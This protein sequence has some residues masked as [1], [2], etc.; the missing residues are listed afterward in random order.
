VTHFTDQHEPRRGARTVDD[1]Q[2]PG[3]PRRPGLRGLPAALWQAG[4]AGLNRL[5]ERSGP[6][7]PLEP[8]HRSW[9]ERL[10]TA[11]LSDVR[12]HADDGAAAAARELDAAAFTRGEDIYVAHDAPPDLLAHE[13]THVLQQRQASTLDASV[14]DRASGLEQAAR[15][16]GD[17]ARVGG[18]AVPAVQRQHADD[19][20]TRAEVQQA[21]TQFLTRA[22]AAQGGRSLRV[23][24]EVK[25]AVLR[26]F[27]G[28]PLG[29]ASAEAWL[30]GPA[31]PGEPADFA[32]QVANRLPASVDRS[33]L[34]GLGR[35]AVAPEAP[36]RFG[37]VKDLVEKSAPGEP[38]KKDDDKEPTSQDKF[39]RGV[40]DLR[41]MRGQ[42]PPPTTYG[43][44]SVDVLRAARIAQGLGQAWSGKTPPKAPSGPTARSYPEVDA[45]IEKIQADALVPAAARGKPDADNYAE[46]REVARDLAR[47]LDIAQQ[48][49]QTS[50][51]LHLPASYASA[52]DKAALEQALE[53]IVHAVRDSLPHHA[54]AVRQVN[55][56][57]GNR[58]V[59]WIP[60]SSAP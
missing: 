53:N 25:D 11:D 33:V 26:L 38:E 52:A 13:V 40:E 24:Q 45:A 59:R 50:V 44:Y 48:Q 30:K 22:R 32:A 20:A 4:N 16:A 29:S 43:P 3:K 47:R 18:G 60:V 28:N 10:F 1:A 27:V 51:D 41:R 17:G 42:P 35:M 9:L 19:R 15:G 57:F 14:G 2:R 49:Q 55:V 5:L 6:G 21:L 58:L 46:A 8:Q 37:R 23:T 54:S 39:E 12:V 34:D 56:W 31:L 7:R 36:G